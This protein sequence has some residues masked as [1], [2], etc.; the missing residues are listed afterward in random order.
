MYRLRALEVKG[1][2]NRGIENRDK[3]HDRIPLSNVVSI[4]MDRLMDC[5]IVWKLLF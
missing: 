1:L 2:P 3:S 5:D 4:D